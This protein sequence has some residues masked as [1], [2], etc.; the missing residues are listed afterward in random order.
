MTPLGGDGGQGPGDRHRDG[1]RR[2][3]GPTPPPEPAPAPGTAGALR[4]WRVLAL[5]VG[6]MLLVLTAVAM[7][8]KY[9]GGDDRLVATVS[10]VHGLLYMVCLLY[11]SDAADE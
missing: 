2:A 8:V 5:A 4:R 9:L 6:V 11:T 3:G 7:P 10:P 1:H